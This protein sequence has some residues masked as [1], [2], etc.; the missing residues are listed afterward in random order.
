MQTLESVR[1]SFLELAPSQNGYY[2]TVYESDVNQ[3]GDIR[4]RYGIPDVG[5]FQHM[6]KQCPLGRPSLGTADIIRTSYIPRGEY[7][8]TRDIRYLKLCG[9]G[10]VQIVPVPNGAFLQ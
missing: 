3:H 6:R 7:G 2:A 5:K 4:A 9:G 10:R 8:N 1:N